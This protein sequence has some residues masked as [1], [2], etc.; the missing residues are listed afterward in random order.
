M[1]KPHDK[2]PPSDNRQGQT[3][4]NHIASIS[5]PAIIHFAGE[6]ELT[7]LANHKAWTS[8]TDLHIHAYSATDRLIDCSGNIFSLPNKKGDEFIDITPTD[9]SLSL[10]K[11][12]ELVKNHLAHSNQCC[13]SKLQL[14]SFLQGM[15]LIDQDN[16]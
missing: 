16:N 6:T 5:W 11:F 4:I 10:G 12:T 9:K 8:D 13:I 15:T 2:V 1:Y 7:Y 14:S 3:P